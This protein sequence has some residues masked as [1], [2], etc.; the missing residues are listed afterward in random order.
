MRQQGHLVEAAHGEATDRRGRVVPS[1]KESALRLQEGADFRGCAKPHCHQ[2]LQIAVQVTASLLNKG[3]VLTM[4]DRG[5]EGRT[6]CSS[7][8]ASF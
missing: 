1:G 6:G 8:G 7:E 5:S 4:G 2:I 3:G